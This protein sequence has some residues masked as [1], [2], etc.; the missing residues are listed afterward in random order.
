MVS[1]PKSQLREIRNAASYL[2]PISEIDRACKYPYTAPEGGFILA[3]GRLFELDQVQLDQMDEDPHRGLLAGRTPVLSVGSNRAPVQLLRK[4]GLDAFLPVTPAR[5]HDCDITHAAILGYYAAIPCTAFPSRGTIVDL[6][7]AWLDDDQLLQMHRTEGINV[8]YDFVLMET[9]EHRLT[10]RSG[11][12]YGYVAR[13]GVLDCGDGEPA[14]LAA[15]PA[16]GRKFKTMTQ[17]EVNAKLR[18]LAEVDDDRS[19][20]Q[21]IAEMQANKFARD[22]IIDRLRPYAIQPHNPPWQLQVVNIDYT[23]SYL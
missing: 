1:I 19:M 21:F 12:V 8:V 17:A 4:F 5:L 2:A 6:N 18:Q 10:L 3:S 13:A 20:P 23:D 14:G 7:V 11:P 22:E 16:Y 9:V 15:I